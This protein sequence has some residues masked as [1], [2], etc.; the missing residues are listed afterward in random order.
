[1][2]DYNFMCVAQCPHCGYD[3]FLKLVDSAS[4][5]PLLWHMLM[6]HL[7][8]CEKRRVARVSYTDEQQEAQAIMQQDL[9]KFG[10][11][12]GSVEQLD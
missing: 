1:M 8:M 3:A 5:L 6:F 2:T 11:T 10:P 7:I 9:A 4:G 12:Q